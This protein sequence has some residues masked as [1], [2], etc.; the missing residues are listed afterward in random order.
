MSSTYLG[1]F[2]CSVSQ[3]TDAKQQRTSFPLCKQLKPGKKYGE[4]SLQSCEIIRKPSFIE[5]LKNGQQM[6]LVVSIDFTGSNGDPRDVGSLHFMNPA[7]PNEY[8]RSIVEVGDVL[9]EYDTD[10]QV[11]GF[12]FG[13]VL[14]T[15]LGE[16]SHFFHLNLQA[17][18]YVAGVQGVLDAYGATMPNLK[19]SGPTNFAPTIRSVTKGA[20]DN[21]EVYTVLLI[22]TDGEITDM[23]DTIRAIVDADDAPL[24]IVIVGVGS[25]SDFQA[26]NILDGDEQRLRSGTK[27]AR[28]DIVQFVPFSQTVTS[29]KL[30][31]AGEVLQEI[32]R[33]F[34]EWKELFGG[35]QQR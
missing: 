2:Q 15:G 26:M 33:Q 11:A 8:V 25:G 6:N 22:I 14:P 28:R 27:I 12:G 16:T 19:F 10:K 23:Q 9:I 35:Q 31:L 32:P 1:G 4:I 29:G 24:S 3:L 17:N 34:V 13:A 7:Q 30:L 5:Y 20:R 18:P 21:L